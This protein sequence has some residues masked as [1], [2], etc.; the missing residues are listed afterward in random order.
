MVVLLVLGAAFA[1]FQYDAAVRLGWADPADSP[2]E[3]APPEG[4]SLPEL[5]APSPVAAP[6][7]GAAADPARVA[8][9]LQPYLADEDLGK[10]VLAVV[11]AAD[12]TALLD[13]GGGA[14]VPASL[15]KII[16]SAAA[17]ESLGPERTFSTRVVR[18]AA[19]GD[20]VLVGGGD[21]YL[22]S[23][24]AETTDYPA[25]ADIVTL[26]RATA[27]KLKAEGSPAVRLAFDDTLFEGPRLSPAWPATYFPEDVVA[28]IS[29]LW[30]DQGAP[31]EG[32][33][34]LAADPAQVAAARFAAELRKAGITVTGTPTRAATP[35][36]AVELAVVHSAPVRLIVD[37]VLASSDNE[38]AE[39]LA[40]HVGIAEGFG[41]SFTGGVAGVGAVLQRLGVPLGPSDVIHDGSGLSRNNRLTPA[42]LLGVLALGA[43]DTHPGQRT[44]LTGLPVAGFNGSLTERFEDAPAAGRGRVRAKTGTL[45]GV[46][47]LAG[48]ATDL[49]GTTLLFVVAADQVRLEDT[50][51]AR[52]TLDRMAAALGACHCAVPR[53]AA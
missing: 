30:V 28:P 47:G 33:R 49:D 21:P 12:G 16:T 26:A 15:T 10:H 38:G 23:E 41:G 29:A 9:A 42:T 14:F 32:Q 5:A 51:D 44:L 24:P 6:L 20:V 37:K 2:E 19:T 40:H 8:A 4:V 35:T 17:L 7:A 11:H 31:P 36:D 43:D 39:L 27:A 22:A 3:V 48:V 1:S 52:E 45:T 25:H 34:G 46:H 50:L 18:G 13:N 53:P